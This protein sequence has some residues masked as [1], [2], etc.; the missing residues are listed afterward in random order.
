MNVV[1]NYAL[2]KI[3]VENLERTKF[4]ENFIKIKNKS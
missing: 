4:L 1:K 2:T 3:V